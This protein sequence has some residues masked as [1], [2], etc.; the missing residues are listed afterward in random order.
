MR[1]LRLFLPAA[2]IGGWLVF[3]VGPSMASSPSPVYDSLPTGGAVQVPSLGLE[4]QQ[5]N[6][7]GNE[8][9]LTKSAKIAKVSVTLT[10]FACQIGAWNTGD[11]QSTAG[12][13]FPT[14]VTL[15]LY[16]HSTS[17]AT[18]G[19]VT[20]GS[21]ILSFTKTYNVKFRP[22]ADANC[23]NTSQFRGSDGNCHNA[24]DL[25]IVFDIPDTKLPT[26]V[27]WGVTYST[28][29]QGPSPI[30]GSGAPQ[31]SLNVGLTPAV[32]KGLNR[33]DDSIFWDTATAANSCAAAPPNG[34]SGS[35]VTGDFNRDGPCNGANNS[36]AGFI[37]AA[38]FTPVS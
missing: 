16:H 38:K 14:P 18:T 13:T 8:V 3:G 10:S 33:T 7:I 24:L 9:I 11:C 25:N 28:D 29:H 2:V 30:G 32:S 17:S 5:F 4:A 21:K 20:P 31:D 26:V 12:A 19:E 27:V 22:S 35:F 37:P 36:W 1:K 23:T 15:T 34:N 6:R